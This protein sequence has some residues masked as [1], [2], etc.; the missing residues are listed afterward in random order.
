MI[1]VNSTLW[2]ASQA[3]AH[4]L[5]NA[6]IHHQH[7]SISMTTTIQI[8]AITSLE[9]SIP[10]ITQIPTTIQIAI[11]TL[12]TILIH[13]TLHIKKQLIPLLC[14]LVLRLVIFSS[15]LLPWFIVILKENPLYKLLIGL[16]HMIL[17]V[18]LF[19]MT[20]TYH[21]L[22]LALTLH[23][24]KPLPIL[25]ILDNFNNIIIL[26]QIKMQYFL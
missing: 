14:L 24:S 12:T 25:R 21:N 19:F 18:I 11:T 2:I 13:T 4:L 8:I 1:S 15:L 22:H 9:M 10:I 23:V 6:P 5:A 17:K 3:V 20:L 26:L 16:L 7:A